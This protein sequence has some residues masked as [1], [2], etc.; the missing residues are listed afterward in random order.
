MLKLLIEKVNTFLGEKN[1]IKWTSFSME[2]I[3]LFFIKISHGFFW[4]LVGPLHHNA[5]VVMSNLAVAVGQLASVEVPAGVPVSNWNELV[6][7][8]A[9][10]N[11]D[12]SIWM[13]SYQSFYLSSNG[14]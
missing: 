4:L 14:N 8:D 3:L 1:N 13:E 10:K 6:S 12:S 11:E 7:V 2:E 9:L 5:L